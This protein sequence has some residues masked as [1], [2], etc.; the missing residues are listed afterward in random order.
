M[1]T[2]I[3]DNFYFYSLYVMMN[4]LFQIPLICRECP[5]RGSLLVV[6]D[7]NLPGPSVVGAPQGR[8]KACEEVIVFR[9]SSFTISKEAQLWKTT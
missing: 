3:Q 7:H 6:G 2:N 8:T 5:N 4:H 9:K 1:I